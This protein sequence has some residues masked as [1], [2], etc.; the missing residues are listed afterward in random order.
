[1]NFRLNKIMQNYV[2]VLYG[3]RSSCYI[4][5]SI[6][7]D[8]S[9]EHLPQVIRTPA[10][11]HRNHPGNRGREGNPIKERKDSRREAKYII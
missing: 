10:D 7:E 4:A 6:E 9:V 11:P 2:N 1:M 3:L 5:S 8:S